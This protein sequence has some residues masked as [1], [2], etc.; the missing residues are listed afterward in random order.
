MKRAAG[1]LLPV[2]ALPSRYGIG[3]FGR[4]A[5]NFVKKLS[6]AG[7]SYWQMLPLNPTSY[8]DSPYQSFSAF[9]LNPY[10]IDLD[11]LKK[12]GYLTSED[13]KPLNHHYSRRIDYGEQYSKRFPILKKACAKAYP[14]QEEEI[15]RFAHLNAF[16]LGDYA[17]FMILKNMHNGASWQEW[18]R[19]Y[20]VRKKFA[21]DKVKAEHMEEY[22]F[23]LWT[24][25][26]AYKQFTRL[27]AYAKRKGIRIIGDIPIYVAMDSADVWSN[28]TIFQLDSCRRP[29]KVA[30]VPPDYFSK[31]GQLWG[32][33]L[34]NYDKI[35]SK[36]CLWWK[37]RVKK[38][39]AYFDVLRID[40]FRG[41]E[42]YY[43]IPYGA[44][45]AEHGEWIKGPGMNLL[46][47]IE[48]AGGKKMEFIAEDLGILTPEVEKLKED[49]GWPGLVIYE[50][51]FDPSDT[52]YK[53]GYLPENYKEN[54]VAYPGTHDNDTLVHFL[55]TADPVTLKPFIYRYLGVKD[56]AS[57]RNE[58]LK[59][60]YSSKADTVIL[61]MQDVLGEDDMRINTP[62]TASGN[63]TYR[64]AKDYDRDETWVRNLK[65]LTEESKRSR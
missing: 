19:K 3:T 21:L 29:V 30:G 22:H 45:T 10:F 12:A 15:E 5:Y 1:V 2:F 38:C 37:R 17:M 8:G 51:G 65:A 4:E 62:G 58:M 39:S 50:F 57:A 31:T 32:N 27:R 60:L 26:T 43:A 44:K 18:E 48:Q 36:H 52:Q 9:A 55:K 56:D 28:Y 54:C 33:P 61:L 23:W 46:T 59:R 25:Y 34:Y 20:R 11:M 6:E 53:N 35:L 13:L 49:I 63:W 64:L 47:A 40:H 14:E 24:Q 16:W 7:Q 42:A 41:F